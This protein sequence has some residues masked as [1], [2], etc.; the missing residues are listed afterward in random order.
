MLYRPFGMWMPD[1]DHVYFADEYNHCVR[2]LVLSDTVFPYLKTSPGLSEGEGCYVY[3]LTHQNGAFTMQ[4]QAATNAP[5]DVVVT[6]MVGQRV[7][8]FTTAT[9]KETD[10]MLHVPPGMYFINVS[11]ERGKWM[12]KVV[13]Q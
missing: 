8:A 1:N 9:N 12:E 7:Q 3:G 13:V 6:N 4:L 5:T 11:T 10:V 2:M